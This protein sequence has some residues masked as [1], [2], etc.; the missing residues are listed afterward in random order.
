MKVI[1]VSQYRYLPLTILPLLI[2][3]GL[4]ACSGWD[5]QEQ[6]RTD[7]EVNQTIKQFKQKDPGITRFFDNAYGYA[8][9]PNVG[10][11]ALGIGGAFGRGQVLE[12]GRPIGRAKLVQLTV[13]FQWGGQAYSELVFFQDRAAL[14]RFKRGDFEFS[15]QASAVAITLGASA[16]AD[17]EQGVAVFTMTKGGLMYEAS[18]GG[19]KFSFEPY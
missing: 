4:S 7:T 3:L 1:A 2:L 9:F 18:I 14:E 5:P 16:T 10:K 15:A 17:Y 6:T 8:V 13:G 19:Q 11:G 12:Q